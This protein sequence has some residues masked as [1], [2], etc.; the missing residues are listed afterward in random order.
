MPLPSVDFLR[1]LEKHL[2]LIYTGKSRLSGDIIDRVMRAYRRGDPEVTSALDNLAAAAT[3]MREALIAESLRRVGEV[4]NFN[5]ENQKRLYDEMT[6]IKIDALIRATSEV[7]V[8]GV[9]ASGAGGGGCLCVLAEPDREHLVVTAAEDLGGRIISFK[10]DF[11]GLRRWT[12]SAM[13][14]TQAINYYG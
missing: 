9:K 6:T 5:W 10:L 14:G 2:L 7:G 4:M 3:Q 12:A 13:S 11:S 8:L 1:E